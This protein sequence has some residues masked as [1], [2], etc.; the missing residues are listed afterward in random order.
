MIVSGQSVLIFKTP[1]YLVNHSV[2]F[3]VMAVRVGDVGYW[4]GYEHQ[5][6]VQSLPDEVIQSAI[7][8]SM[9]GWHC[10]AAQVAVQF[11]KERDGVQ[12]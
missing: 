3:P 9:F 8:G 4:Q 11:A 7:E 12:E 1:E 6:E 2:K 5:A 10:P